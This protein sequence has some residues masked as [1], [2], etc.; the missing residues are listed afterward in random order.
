MHVTICHIYRQPGRTQR[1]LVKPF[2]HISLPYSCHESRLP[3]RDPLRAED[4]ERAD[5]YCPSRFDSLDPENPDHELLQYLG[6]IFIVVLTTRQVVAP[7]QVVATSLQDYR[8]HRLE[9]RLLLAKQAESSQEKLKCIKDTYANMILFEMGTLKGK[10]QSTNGEELQKWLNMAEGTA[11]VFGAYYGGI[12]V[13]DG[14][15]TKEGL[16]LVANLFLDPPTDTWK[17]TFKGAVL[18]DKRPPSTTKSSSM[19]PSSKTASFKSASSASGA[20]SA[21]ES[22]EPGASNA[23]PGPGPDE[24]DW[25][26]M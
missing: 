11:R 17:D 24:D 15:V 2:N 7:C 6:S 25:V 13:L 19:Q 23:T 26:F 16:D 22:Q 20:P 12:R 10:I 5:E 18:A 9:Y 3:I 21:L 14:A 1:I 4:H 8:L